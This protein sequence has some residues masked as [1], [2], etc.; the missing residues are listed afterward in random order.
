MTDSLVPQDWQ[1]YY[2]LKYDSGFVLYIPF[3]KQVI[4]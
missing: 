3:Y 4:S 1:I 2:H